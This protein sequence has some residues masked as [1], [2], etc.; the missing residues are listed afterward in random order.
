MRVGSKEKGEVFGKD[1][2][3]L[4]LRLEEQ[5]DGTFGP[6]W[7]QVRKQ[8]VSSSLLLDQ[9]PSQTVSMSVNPC[10]LLFPSDGLF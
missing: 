2:M 9:W 8:T 10:P 5:V 4:V 3:K 1:Q 6:V 7:K